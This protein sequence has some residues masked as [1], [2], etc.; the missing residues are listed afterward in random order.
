MIFWGHVRSTDSVR[1]SK[2]KGQG[3][4]SIFIVFF[5]VSYRFKNNTAHLKVVLLL[6]F[7]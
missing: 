3:E 7:V 6:E 1:A 5:V 2:N 4:I